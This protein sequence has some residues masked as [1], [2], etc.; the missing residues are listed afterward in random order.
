MHPGE[1]VRPQVNQGVTSQGGE[2]SGVEGPAEAEKRE[3]LDRPGNGAVTFP[4]STNSPR[5]GVANTSG[6]MLFQA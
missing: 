4:R 2:D 5:G 6:H 1:E 3:P